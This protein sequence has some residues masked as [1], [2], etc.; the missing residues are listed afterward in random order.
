M[1]L[2][3]RTLILVADGR[4][5]RLFEESRRGGPL[6]EHP[7]WVAGLTPPHVT[8]PGPRGGVHDR[9]GHGSH[10]TAHGG[11]RE[12]AETEFLAA[13]AKHLASVF[14]DHGFDQLILI[15]APR[16]LG[17]LRRHLPDGLKTRLALSEPHDRVSASLADIQQ[18]VR[19]L[20]RISA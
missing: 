13:L 5:A 4:K 12:K 17:V 2:D 6:V 19:A 8:S 3:S 16:A 18:A 10:A 15:A 9:F 1:I 7:E 14:D 20:R 11:G